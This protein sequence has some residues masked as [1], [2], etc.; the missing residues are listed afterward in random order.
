MTAE[1]PIFFGGEELR[2]LPEHGV[3]C[4]RTRTVW[5]ADLHL[6]KEESFRKSGFPVPDLREDDLSRLSHMLERTSANQLVILG[7]LIHARSG[8]STRLTEEFSNWRVQHAGIDIVLIR[9]NHDQHA[10]DPPSEWQLRCVDAP[11]AAGDLLQSHVPL[12]DNVRPNLAGHLHPKYRLRS[13]AEDLKFPC[14]LLRRQTLVLPAFGR[15]IDHGLIVPHVAD[16][17]YIVVEG[18]IIHAKRSRTTC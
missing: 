12:F 5:V 1:I 7:D 14:F 3:W 18:E 4:P 2:L 15:F 8:L 13:R 11:H 6:G 9:G 16:D 17:I 10:G